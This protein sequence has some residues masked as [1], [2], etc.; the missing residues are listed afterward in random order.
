MTVLFVGI[1]H[2][3]APLTTVES[4]AFSTVDAVG[5]LARIVQ[6]DVAPSLPLRELVILST[7]HRVELYAVPSDDIT[8]PSV[9]LEAMTNLLGSRAPHGESTDAGF[10]RLIGTEATRHLFRVAAGLESMV[11]GESDV[12][13][14]VASALATAV[15]VGA[16]GPVLTPLFE[17]AVRVGRRAR[18]ETAIGT[19]AS[20]GMIAAQ[21]ADEVAEDELRGRRAL[22]VGTGKIGR[23]AAKALRANGFWEMV[24][25]PSPGAD[26]DALAT[27]LSAELVTPDAIP[28]ALA[29]ADLVLACASPPGQIDAAMVRQA[30]RGRMARPLAFIDLAAGGALDPAVNDLAG[31]HVVTAS[32]LRERIETALAGRRREAPLVETIV[33]E[34]LRVVQA[35]AE[36]RSLSGVVAALRARAEEI[37]QRE[38]SRALSGLPDADPAVRAQL[39]WLSVSLVNK[40]LDEP[41]RRLRAEAGQGPANPYADVTRELFGLAGER[42]GRPPA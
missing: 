29:E 37:R 19:A 28:R 24:V 33:E 11:L 4:L 38:L 21:I 36:G 35:R 1:S 23:A 13:H 25:A 10:R 12:L 17:S 32:D 3:T 6:G 5:T 42:P 31:V 8:R 40:L 34:E 39:E 41:T 14:Q 22:L 18:A 16:A 7:C 15:R 27:E 30:M 26:T 9:A 20:V 2:A